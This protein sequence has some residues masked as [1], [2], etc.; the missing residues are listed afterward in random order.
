MLST[1]KSYSPP[2][3]SPKKTNKGKVKLILKIQP[4]EELS[5][6]EISETLEN[7]K[8]EEKYESKYTCTEIL[9]DILDD[10]IKQVE[11][12]EVEKELDVILDNELK[13]EM[14]IQTLKNINWQKFHQLCVMI[15]SEL[16]DAQWRFLKAVFLERAV[17]NYSDNKLVYVGNDKKGCDFIV[18]SLDNLKI[19]MKY[20]TE[21]L[22]TGKKECLR[23]NCKA[24]TLLNSKGTNTHSNLPETYADYLMIVESKGAAVI[25]K[26][27]LKKYVISNG[28]SLS[29][30]IPTNDLTLIYKPNDIKSISTTTENKNLHIK[31][32]FIDLI[33]KII[34]SV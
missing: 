3:T 16:N 21:A 19:E 29:A 6:N 17:S 2:S 15:G 28:D 9:N 34:N 33:D 26:Q 11:K 12:N 27:N 8:M 31:D 13:E 14:L 30:T 10:I 32:Q 24:I 4:E 18:P 23:E 7:L 25:S 5:V 20:T 22:F 1:L